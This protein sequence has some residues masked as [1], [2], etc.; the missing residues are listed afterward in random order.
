MAP[1]R[2]NI[3]LVDDEPPS[4]RLF[5]MS[6]Q[7]AASAATLY[8]V[9]TA[10]EAV[11]ALDRRERFID[12]IGVDLVVLDLNMTPVDG[13]EILQRIRGNADPK[14]ATKPVIVMSSSAHREDISRAYQCGATSYIVKPVSLEAMHDVVASLARYWFDVVSLPER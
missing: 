3:L 6:L 5:E 10:T 12:V 1:Q 8:W 4:A 7:K 9:A 2:F 11:E 14:L 13:F